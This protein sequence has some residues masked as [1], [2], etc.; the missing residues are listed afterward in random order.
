MFHVCALTTEGALTK[1]GE[2]VCW[3]RPAEKYAHGQDDPPPG[4]FTVISAGHWTTCALTADG[5]RRG[6]VLGR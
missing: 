5:G 3:G 2:A 1:D 6:S 4:R